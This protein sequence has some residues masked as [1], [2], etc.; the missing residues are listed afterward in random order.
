MVM[1]KSVS[2]NSCNWILLVRA[3]QQTK[4]FSKSTKVTLEKVWNMSK[5]NNK[6]ITATS[7]R[8]SVIF[9]VNFEDML[10]VFLVFL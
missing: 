3:A 4:P 7:E 6:N 2:A 8:H 5:V 1:V 9:I 10:N